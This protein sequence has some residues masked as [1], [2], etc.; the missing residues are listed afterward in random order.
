MG[1]NFGAALGGFADQVVSD[2]EDKEKEV[3]LRTRT[4]LDR[5]VAET[6]ANRKEYKTNKKKVQEQL[7]S[8]VS[9]FGDDPDRWNKA[10]AIVAGGDAH[11]AKMS[12][13]FAKAQDNKQNVNEIYKLTKSENDVGLKG[14]QDTTNSLVQMAQIA[15][16]SFGA[17]GQMSSLLG[18]TDMSKVYQRG[19]QEFEKAGLLDAIPTATETGATYGSGNLDLSKI[20]TDA[21]SVDQQKANILSALTTNEV[22][23]PEHDAALKKQSI[24]NSFEESNSLALKIAKEQNKTKG[25]ATRSFYMT[26]L[27]NGLAGIENKFKDPLVKGLDGK[28]IED[29]AKKSEFKEQS[30]LKYKTD[31][32][33]NL[34]RNPGGLSSNGLEVIQGDPQLNEIYKNIMDAEQNKIT[35]DGDKKED[36][37]KSFFEKQEDIL[38]KKNQ[39]E[40]IQK[41]KD[42]FITKYGDDIN[43]AA[44]DLLNIKKSNGKKRTKKEVFDTLRKIYPDKSEEDIYKIVTDVQGTVVVSDTTKP[45][46]RP[47]DD[48]GFFGIGPDSDKRNKEQDDWD[49]KYGG[50]LNPSTGLPLRKNNRNRSK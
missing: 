22:G 18:S 19:R 37:D 48:G 24:L 14:I 4:I 31:F 23:T 45:N 3:K 20:N 29:P 1:F 42:K 40:V 30:I 16:P 38:K 6:A 12:Q 47:K 50:V 2:I 7:N 21:K 36:N 41:K 28:T 17:S 39:E 33:N 11:V 5:H 34:I 10:R 26:T 13:Y 49:K 46:P 8:I 15:K 27:K 35:G 25:N 32:V 44:T 9:Y 43:K